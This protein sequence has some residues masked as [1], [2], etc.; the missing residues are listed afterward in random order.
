MS[1]SARSRDDAVAG[2]TGAGLHG[3]F[4]R[5]MTW[6]HTW[7][8]MLAGVVL[9]FMFVTGT[10]G[11]A[12]TEINRWMAPDDMQANRPVDDATTMFSRAYDMVER[13]MPDATYVGIEIPAIPGDHGW[14]SLSA[15]AEPPATDAE[16]E[17]PE[18]HEDHEGHVE[19]E[20]REPL[21]IRLDPATYQEIPAPSREIGGGDELYRMH[22]ALQYV[23]HSSL[24][25]EDTIGW[26]GLIVSS[27]AMFLLI[28][29]LT[30]I[31]AHRRLLKDLVTFRP[32]R[33]P[34]SW[35]DAHNLASV[36]A[37]PFVV[38]ITYSGLIFMSS[39]FM[40]TIDRA[41]YG[42]ERDDPN[43]GC[44]DP[45][46]FWC[47]IPEPTGVAAPS[48][49]IEPMIATTERLRTD[50]P[51]MYVT[52]YNRGD[53]ASIVTVE[54]LDDLG[55]I[56]GIVFSGTSGEL[57][58]DYETQHY[59]DLAS[60]TKDALLS[61]HTGTFAGP[62]LRWAYLL[63]GAAGSAMVATGMILWAVRRRE[64]AERRDGKPSFGLV[65]VERSM[66]AVVVGLLVAVVAYFWSNRL[67]PYVFEDPE[68]WEIDALFVVWGLCFLHAS[69]RPSRAAYRE[70]IAA[71]AVLSTLLPL[72][73]VFASGRHL[74]MTLFGGEARRDLGVAAIDLTF[75]AVGALAGITA[76]RMGSSS[77]AATP[78]RPG[79]FAPVVT[80]VGA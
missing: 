22:Y 21:D 67:L 74:G 41:A 59:D 66:V 69:L 20:P 60:R 32:R 51:V 37:L 76:W 24:F 33:G 16:P 18:E 43:Y 19:P 71:L 2:A 14:K 34:R 31:V 61:L 78:G 62:V 72:V 63:A 75:L 64:R 13:Q 36:L 47:S 70:Q 17:E 11:Y 52:V 23:P 53:E 1:A 48:A 29:V 4:R 6:L 54:T 30:G 57:L 35:L 26:S 65:A 42:S 56:G 80:E 38:M 39:G 15:Y 25:G 49:P 45:D 9:F 58:S 40:P 44:D 55:E 12:A 79:V 68:R 7:V 28:S 46:V 8:G 3:S 27:A 10:T 50:G 73:N 5:S 77:P